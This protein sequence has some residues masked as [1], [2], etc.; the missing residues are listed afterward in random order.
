MAQILDVLLQNVSL[1]ALESE[2]DLL[3]EH[4]LLEV[5]KRAVGLSDAWLARILQ[6][7]FSLENLSPRTYHRNGQMLSRKSRQVVEDLNGLEFIANVG[8]DALNAVFHENR[9]EE[10]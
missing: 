1:Q 10:A 8:F 2:T 5:I 7:L 9:E 3:V 6:I 4:S